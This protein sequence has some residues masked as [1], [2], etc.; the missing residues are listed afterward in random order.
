MEKITPFVTSIWIDELPDQTYLLDKILEIRD[1][2]SNKNIKKSNRGGWQSEPFSE[3][4]NFFMI[5][6][7]TQIK[8]KIKKVYTELGISKNPDIKNYWFNC[9]LKGDYNK[10]HVHPYSFVSAVLYLS[11]STD[12]GNI[13]FERP[14][15][16]ENFIDDISVLTKENYK[17]FYIIPKNNLLVVFPSYLPHYVEKNNSDHSRISVSFNFG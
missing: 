15:Q 12:C 1:K 3:S 13:I 4:S 9:N 7:I 5:D 11:T 16:F 6:T 17:T 14:D 2:D 8:D 10:T